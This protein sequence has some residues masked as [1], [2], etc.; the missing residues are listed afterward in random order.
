MD[1]KGRENRNEKG[2]KLV[3]EQY[4]HFYTDTGHCRKL[5]T[6]KLW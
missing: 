6:A 4:S 1:G 5:T 3:M 2:R